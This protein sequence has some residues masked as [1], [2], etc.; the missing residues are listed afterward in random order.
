MNND[1]GRG[2]LTNRSR[3]IE[4][5][6]T[7]LIK[8]DTRSESIRSR[9]KIIPSHLDPPTLIDPGLFE[10]SRS[11]CYYGRIFKSIKYNLAFT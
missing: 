2:M 10:T 1:Y 8:I 5:P 7:I 9:D 6:V 4:I 3:V 11:I